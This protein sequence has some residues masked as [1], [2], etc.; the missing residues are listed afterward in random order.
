MDLLRQIT[1][2]PMDPDYAL[3]AARREPRTTGRRRWPLALATVLAG[4][5]FAIAAVQNTQRAPVLAT[6]REELIAR[7]KTAEVGLETQRAQV[8]A[9]DADIT[10]LRASAASGDG[11]AEAKL[12]DIDE[13]GVSVGTVAVTGPGVV[14]VVDDATGAD[15]DT[16][17]QVL[18]LDLQIL[19]NGLW[20]AGAEAISV[21]GHRL[22]TL[23][24]IRGAGE[25]ITVDYRSLTR[26]YVI[27]AIGDQRT[28]PASF[29]QTDAGAWWTDLSR[30]RGMTFA[31]SGVD[32]LTLDADPGMVLRYARPSR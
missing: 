29:A 22:S 27:E 31:I 3:V 1:E 26:P 8:A 4:A 15:N 16:R 21:N 23:T 13:L 30:N 6:E 7:I 32:E 28:L 19:V 2:Q 10:R 9:L 17:D 25:A 18:D 12:A 20:E 5:L 11:A 14:V 24:A